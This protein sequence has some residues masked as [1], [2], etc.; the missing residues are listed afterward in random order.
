MLDESDVNTIGVGYTLASGK[1]YCPIPVFHKFIEKL[2]DRPIF[3][4]ELASND[5]W[6]EMKLEFERQ[7]KEYLK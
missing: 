3:T 6:G 2:L 7:T 1:L 5:L 4:H